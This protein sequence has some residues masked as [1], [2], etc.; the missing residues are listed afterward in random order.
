VSG[1]LV[2]IMRLSSFVV[3]LALVAGLVALLVSRDSAHIATSPQTPGGRGMRKRA[4]AWFIEV[5]R[6]RHA[7][8]DGDSDGESEHSKDKFALPAMRRRM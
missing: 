1:E 2:V 7:D 3:T 8:G 4:L 5:M 6:L